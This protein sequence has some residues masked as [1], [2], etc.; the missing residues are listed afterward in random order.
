MNP[1]TS[2]HSPGKAPTPTMVE[3]LVASESLCRRMLAQEYWAAE[4][5]YRLI[6]AKLPR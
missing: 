5:C 2:A 6:S 4:G 3:S 1:R